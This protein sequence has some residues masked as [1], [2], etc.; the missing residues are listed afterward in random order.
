MST[1]E[2]F[3]RQQI[4][5]TRCCAGEFIEFQEVDP[6][7]TYRPIGSATPLDVVR[8]FGLFSALHR[9]SPYPSLFIFA[10]FQK[11]RSDLVESY[12]DFTDV[13]DTELLPRRNGQYVS[14]QLIRNVLA[15]PEICLSFCVLLD[16]R[17]PDLIAAW[18]ATTRCVRIPRLRNEV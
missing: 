6:I 7:S 16:A 12:R 5:R 9:H 13:F 17:R 4:R 2:E 14:Y 8:Y 3:C 11:Q 10:D 15:A 1:R 18:F